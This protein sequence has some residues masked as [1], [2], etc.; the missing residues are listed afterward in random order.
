MSMTRTIDY[1]VSGDAMIP[2]PCRV[3]RRWEE[4][5]GTV[6]LELQAP[7]EDF[8]FQP[9]QFNM[10]YVFGVGEVPIS[11][12]G[13]PR[14]RDRLVHTSRSVGFT[15]QAI[16]RLKEGDTVGVRGPFGSAWPLPVASGKDV[17]VIAG[18]L[19][20]APLRPAIYQLLSQRERY[21]N[22]SILYG[23]KSPAEVLYSQELALWRKQRKISV[24]VT[25]D[26]ADR[27]WSEKVGVVPR[28][29]AGCRFDPGNVVV[30]VCGPEAMMRYTVQELVAC[31]VSCASIFIS[32]ERNMQCALGYCG[33]CQ[34]GPHFIC[35]DGPVLRYDQIEHLFNLREI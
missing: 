7:V 12:S 6:S 22:I 31:G 15:T 34:F 29:I 2:V 26:F 3:L 30:L 24:D 10:L 20:L 11:I 25:V 23:A 5:A 14:R 13:D 33:H 8:A 1:T 19:G 9:G 21:G 35:K 32:M 4:L 17:L 28:L 27:G 18:G 16:N